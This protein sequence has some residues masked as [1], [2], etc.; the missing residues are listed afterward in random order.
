MNYCRNKHA[1]KTINQVDCIVP[2]YIFIVHTVNGHWNTWSNWSACSTSCGQGSKTRT[3]A[4]SNPKPM[5]GGRSCTGS[6]L[7]TNTCLMKVCPGKLSYMNIKTVTAKSLFLSLHSLSYPSLYLSLPLFLS[8]FLSLSIFLSLSLSP[9][10]LCL[11]SICYHSLYLSLSLP[12]SLS[13]SLSLSLSLSFSTLSLSLSLF[14]SLS[15][16]IY[17]SLSPSRMSRLFGSVSSVSIYVFLLSYDF[18]Y[19]TVGLY[20]RLLC[21]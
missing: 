2:L 19:I 10:S 6:S 18:L 11:Y 4:C 12:L 14:L 20:L 16:S 17:L 15:L 8:L 21:K 7:S 3:R 9:L 1:N 13:P 5:N